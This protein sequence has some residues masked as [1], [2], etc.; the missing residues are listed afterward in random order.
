MGY[1]HSIQTFGTVDQCAISTAADLLRR[2]RRLIKSICPDL[3]GDQRKLPDGDVAD[4]SFSG[5]VQNENCRMIFEL[6]HEKISIFAADIFKSAVSVECVDFQ[7]FEN[8]FADIR[9]FCA[10]FGSIESCLSDA[11]DAIGIVSAVY[12]VDQSF[13]AVDQH[14]AFG[15]DGNTF[16][17]EIFAVFRPVD[18]GEDG[19]FFQQHFAVFIQSFH[20]DFVFARNHGIRGADP[21]LTVLTDF[22]IN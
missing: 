18:N 9:I 22:D 11:S 5:N 13:S 2:M 21:L 15:I 14:I 1:I 7:S 8:P 12:A 3:Q 16:D 17:R 6:L 10:D 20:N 4:F 19:G